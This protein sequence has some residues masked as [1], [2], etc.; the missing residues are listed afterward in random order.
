MEYPIG[1][2]QTAKHPGID[3]QVKK[4][5]FIKICVL[6]L[7]VISL[8]TAYNRPSSVISKYIGQVS[9]VKILFK[10]DV[11][12]VKLPDREYFIDYSLDPTINRGDSIFEYWIDYQLSGISTAD[13]RLIYPLVIYGSH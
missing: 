10:N 13:R 4:R 12:W 11:V 2:V 5:L 1:N 3:S 7:F 9:D 6:I 8:L